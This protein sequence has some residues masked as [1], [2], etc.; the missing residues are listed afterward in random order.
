MSV[1]FEPK[2]SPRRIEKWFSQKAS[3]IYFQCYFREGSYPIFLDL[4][5]VIF[6]FV[7]W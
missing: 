2:K 6:Y 1:Y 5:K 4:F 3:R 7:P